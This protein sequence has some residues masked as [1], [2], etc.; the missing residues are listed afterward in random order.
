MSLFRSSLN[1]LQKPELGLQIGRHL[2]LKEA[3]PLAGL[4]ELIHPVIIVGDLSKTEGS[5]ILPVRRPYAG[6]A[7]GTGAAGLQARAQLKNPAG[8]GIIV[9]V[10]AIRCTSPFSGNWTI[11]RLDTDLFSLLAG[12][13]FS[14]ILNTRSTVSGSIQGAVA[15]APAAQI[16]FD[17]NGAVGSQGSPL[18]Q[19][20]ANSST[21]QTHFYWNPINPV[22]L[23]EATGVV[24]DYTLAA[25][26][27][28]VSFEW[29]EVGKEPHA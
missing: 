24:V 17:S 26:L 27:I 20:F 22:V 1:K 16:R 4:H 15:A 28:Q 2:G 8:S 18:W 11:A 29:E 6:I 19:E 13:T 5:D 25:G 12:G 14:G 9:I 10:K 21:A 3:V 7:S 23:G